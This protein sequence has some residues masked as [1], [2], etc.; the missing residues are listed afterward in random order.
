MLKVGITGGI[1][2]GKSVVCRVFKTLGIPVFNAD[3]TA[4]MLMDTDDNLVSGIKSI[5]GDN[6]YTL[7]KL[8]RAKLANQVFRQPELL[9]QLNAIVHPATI[10]YGKQWMAAQ[11]S[12]YTIKEA[13]IFFESGSYK[14]MDVMI[15]VA[16]PTGLRIARAM[17]RPDMTQ[18][19]VLERIAAQMDADEK[20]ARCDYV[21]TNDDNT[22]IIPQVVKI[23]QALLTRAKN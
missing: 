12:A 23:H 21:I 20:M 4:K 9:Q 17:Q 8:N 19:K 14:D 18:D 2:A 5:F 11:T 13:A 6:I 10:E 3:H 15:G 1:G 16:A 22:A 7:G